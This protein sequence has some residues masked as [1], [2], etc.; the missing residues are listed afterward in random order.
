MRAAGL[1]FGTLYLIRP[2]GYVAL[3]DSRAD[4][5]RLTQYFAERGLTQLS[6]DESPV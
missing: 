5:E 2:D 3:V 1:R 4:P 6:A